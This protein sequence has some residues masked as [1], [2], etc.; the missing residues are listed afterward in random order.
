[1]TCPTP[2]KRGYSNRMA[3]DTALNVAKNQWRRH[4]WRAEAP[5]ERIYQCPC[6]VWHLTHVARKEMVA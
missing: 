4:P 2:D 6:G 1:M 5:P 3:A